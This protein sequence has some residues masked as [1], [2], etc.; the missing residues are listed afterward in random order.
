MADEREQWVQPEPEVMEGE[1]ELP[2]QP[3]APLDPYTPEP[4]PRP[5]EGRAFRAMWLAIAVL[6][7]V[8]A[9]VLYAAL[10]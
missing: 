7:V 10:R 4:G 6:A 8:A 3:N 9:I 1:D 5:G 2:R